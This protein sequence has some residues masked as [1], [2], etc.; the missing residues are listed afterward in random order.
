MEQVEH[1]VLMVKWA[2]LESQEK[3]DWLGWTE[4][5]DPRVR[6]VCYTKAS[7]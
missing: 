2:P 7:R 4:D 6:G 5:L 3:L 1:Q